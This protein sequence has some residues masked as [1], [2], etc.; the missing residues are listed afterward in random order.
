M[1][2]PFGFFAVAEQSMNAIFRRPEL[3]RTNGNFG[4]R[5]NA[6]SMDKDVAYA[7]DISS[8][9]AALS[10]L[11]ATLDLAK[12]AVEARDETKIAAIK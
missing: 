1:R 12:L 4:R 9:S 3:R 8:V 2:A 11:K 5:Y 7:M 10:S 6:G